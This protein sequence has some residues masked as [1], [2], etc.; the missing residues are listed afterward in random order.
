T[1]IIDGKATTKIIEQ[2]VTETSASVRELAGTDTTF[3]TVEGAA[4]TADDVTKRAKDGLT[5]LISADGKA[6][7]KG[8]L[9]AARPD[10]VVVTSPGLA[11]SMPPAVPGVPV[12]LT[13][14]PR[15][16]LLAA[17]ADGKVRLACNPV[18]D[19]AFATDQVFVQGN[20]GVVVV[21]G[22]MQGKVF[23]QGG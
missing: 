4:L 11:G 1:E 23:V 20:G 16:V 2:E 18:T 7:P 3:A 8:W 6:I 21:R 9:R 12:A 15:L 13:P 22:A 14:A 19:P 5:L 10:A 17:D